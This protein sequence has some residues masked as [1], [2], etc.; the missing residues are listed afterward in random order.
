MQIVADTG[1]L[2]SF[3]KLDQGFELLFRIVN[4][5]FVPRPVLEE[6]CVGRGQ[7]AQYE[8]LLLGKGSL[9]VLDNFF[10]DQRTANLDYGEQFA[11]SAALSLKLRLLIEDREARQT[12]S[13]MGVTTIG[14]AGLI[15]KG[16]QAGSITAQ[17]YK[18]AIT[19]LYLKRRINVSLFEQFISQIG[20]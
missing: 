2:I 10:P 20:R 11:V 6:L 9:V 8:S 15:L 4:E 7:A 13:N 18:G 16:L 14:S 19:Q 17:E 12:A 1:G 3:E 5:V